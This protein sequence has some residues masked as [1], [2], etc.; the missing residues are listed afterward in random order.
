MTLLWAWVSD[1]RISSFASYLFLCSIDVG[2][3]CYRTTM[4]LVWISLPSMC[5]LFN[6]SVLDCSQEATVTAPS[7][8]T[9]G[10]YNAPIILFSFLIGLVCCKKFTILNQDINSWWIVTAMTMSSAIEA[11]VSTMWVLFATLLTK[12]IWQLDRFVGLGEDPQVLAI[13]APSL[14]AVRLLLESLI[15]PNEWLFCMCRWLRLGILTSQEECHR[16]ESWTLPRNHFDMLIVHICNPPNQCLF[17]LKLVGNTISFF[18]IDFGV[19]VWNPQGHFDWV[20]IE[21][22]VA[23]TSVW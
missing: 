5:V 23:D 22:L 15:V 18:F 2:L 7:Y 9:S 8:N 21:N 16:S 4:L 17:N 10:Q 14:F 19:N 13:R 20:E 3:L 12:D 6:C 1:S 11:G